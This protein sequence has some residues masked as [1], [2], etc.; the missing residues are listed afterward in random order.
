MFKARNIPII[1]ILLS[2]SLLPIFFIYLLYNFYYIPLYEKNILEDKKEYLQNLMSYKL[3]YYKLLL[4]KLNKSDADTNLIKSSAIEYLSTLSL[5][6]N[7]YFFAFNYQ[8]T[9][10]IVHPLRT[11]LINKKAYNIKDAD[12]NIIY[13]RFIEELKTKN[14]AFITY[15]QKVEHNILPKMSL[16]YKD[17]V[18]K[19]IIGTGIYIDDV[20]HKMQILRRKANSLFF[21][22]TSLTFLLTYIIAKN[23]TNRIQRILEFAENINNK[24]FNYQLFDEYN[25]ELGKLSLILNSMVQKL[26]KSISIIEQE[27]ELAL[28][29][30]KIKLYLLTSLS[31]NFKL[32][33]LKLLG[34]LTYDIQILKNSNP[35][36]KTTATLINN[37]FIQIEQISQT[38]E[39][40]ELQKYKFQDISLTELFHKLLSKHSSIIATRNIQVS[41]KIIKERIKLY[42]DEYLITELIDFILINYINY[43]FDTKINITL[44]A[45]K[46]SE[47]LKAHIKFELISDNEINYTSL[48]GI[49]DLYYQSLI[50]TPENENLILAT[51]L[52]RKIN[53]N[54]IVQ[55]QQNIFILEIIIPCYFMI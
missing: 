7:K 12:G 50:Q 26:K 21:I 27:K 30:N 37:L 25:D 38:L 55:E 5:N 1:F 49:K 8:D 15:N 43:S 31:E 11:E 45:L 10:L 52:M 9:T 36:L 48:K 6:K 39:L 35:I 19:F 23:I 53:G 29:R 22:L 4:S 28:Q 40:N 16:I 20:E 42:F 17:T 46:T 33:L 41:L 34:L 24:N 32:P 47:D 54:I 51:E 3:E 14:P 13:L 18:F 44:D 2:L